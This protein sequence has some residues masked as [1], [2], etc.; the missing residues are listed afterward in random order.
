MLAGLVAGGGAAATAVGPITN[1]TSTQTRSAL[2]SFVAA[3]NAGD[4]R[5][6][7]SLFA[8]PQWFHWYSSGGPG[9][10]IDP[11]ARNR[12]TLVGYFRAR[13]AQR[14][15]FRLGSVTF[16]GSSLG[17]GNFVFAGQRSAADYRG[18]AWLAVAGKGATLCEG[19]TVKLAV[20]SVGGPAA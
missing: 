19:A 18:G 6:L 17:Y 16:N 15:R 2:R 8:G 4:Y 7:D 9:L 10:R 5:R 11:A 3:F 14:D 20:L 12:T 1:C 13:H